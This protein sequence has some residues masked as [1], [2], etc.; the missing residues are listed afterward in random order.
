MP[1]LAI[2]NDVLDIS[3]MEAGKLK[4]EES[5]VSLRSLV[6]KAIRMLEPKA[7]H[8][9]L[10]LTCKID[11]AVPDSLLADPSRLHQCIV[12][13]AH[14]L[15]STWERAELHAFVEHSRPPYVSARLGNPISYLHPLGWI[16]HSFV[17]SWRWLHRKARGL[18]LVEMH[19]TEKPCLS[20]WLGLQ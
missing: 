8:K 3:K 4:L 7:Q 10:G 18:L 17:D 12:S 2:V 9:G 5:P 6:A 13:V 15:S 1:Q 11:D 19:P 14:I 16:S 20:D